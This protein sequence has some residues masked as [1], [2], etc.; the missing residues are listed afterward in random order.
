VKLFT[1]GMLDDSPVFMMDLDLESSGPMD[2]N[3]KDKDDVKSDMEIQDQVGIEDQM[4][5][6]Q[7][8][9][10]SLLAPNINWLDT[11]ASGVEN[12]AAASWNNLGA[13]TGANKTDAW[14]LAASATISKT[15]LEVMASR[16]CSRLKLSIRSNKNLARG[17]LLY[18]AGDS[19]ITFRLGLN[20]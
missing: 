17:I 11:T 9:E 12:H 16:T 14:I 18:L 1:V 20:L 10:Y 19:D 5:Q 15:C 7:Q 8:L 4:A 3:L 13:G 2:S 6:P